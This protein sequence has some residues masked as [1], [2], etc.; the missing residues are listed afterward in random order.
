MIAWRP[1][2]QA[3]SIF[4]LIA[5]LEPLTTVSLYPSLRLLSVALLKTQQ[6]EMVGTLRYDQFKSLRSV[7][8]ANRSGHPVKIP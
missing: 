1:T 4:C 6:Q 8:P 5:H 2:M 3:S 7:Q